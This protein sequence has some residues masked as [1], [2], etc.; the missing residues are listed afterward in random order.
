MSGVK[1]DYWDTKHVPVSLNHINNLLYNGI[2]MRWAN[3]TCHEA[4]K[5]G[6]K[7]QA[8]YFCRPAHS[9]IPFNHPGH[10]SAQMDVFNLC[11]LLIP[12]PCHI[13]DKTPIPRFAQSNQWCEI[14]MEMTRFIAP[15]T[16]RKG[17]SGTSY[18]EKA[19]SRF[20]DLTS[21]W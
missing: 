5:E 16:V 20:R 2:S 21:L 13:T 14:Q 1:S 8:T 19:T 6:L 11:R 12:S 3:W 9:H 10:W 7:E 4:T 18:R 15:Y 17:Y